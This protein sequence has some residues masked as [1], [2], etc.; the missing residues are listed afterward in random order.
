MSLDTLLNPQQRLF[1]AEIIKGNNLTQAYK[2]AG[3]R[4]KSDAQAQRDAAKL[5][6]NP[7]VRAARERA[8]QAVEA[9]AQLT[10]NDILDELEEARQGAMRDGVW[11]AAV[12]ASMGK[13]RI[14]G[15]VV[16]RAQVDLTL[17]KPALSSKELELDEAEW[18]RQFDSPA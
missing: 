3:Y 5:A 8:L 14:L 18:K 10:A 17:H 6:R 7:V 2:K 4:A 13:A 15:L 1:V 9:R 12:A 11:Q 16:N